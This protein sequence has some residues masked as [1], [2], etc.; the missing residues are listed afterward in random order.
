M[1]FR[2]D[3]HMHLFEHGF[4]HSLAGRPGVNIDEVACY[5]SLR[6]SH[7]VGHALVVGYA[8]E[9]F[10]AGNNAFLAELVK[11]RSWVKP[12]AF[13]DLADPLNRETLERFESEGFVGVSMYVF[14]D[15]DVTTIAATSDQVWQRLVERRAL[16]SVNSKGKCWS[17]WLPVLERH[18]KLRLLVSHLGLPPQ[19]SQPPDEVTAQA[20][21]APVL[22]LAAFDQVHVKL[23]G[24]YAISDPGFDYPHEASWP[25]VYA[26]LKAFGSGRLLWASDFSPHLDMLSFPQ[27]FGL[28]EEMPFLNDNDCRFIEGDNLKRLLGEC[29]G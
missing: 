16:I 28:F 1:S 7:D 2:A 27:T 25:Y 10:A 3:A 6:Q 11:T 14:N 29:V 20:V 18:P 15:E 8:G 23:S 22:A 19:V 21:M 13:V 12:V 9:P 5:E 4:G 17:A 26:L 24:F